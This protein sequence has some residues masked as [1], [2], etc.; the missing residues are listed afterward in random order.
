MT[1][2]NFPK[3][4]PAD[5]FRYFKVFS[6]YIGT[7][8]LAF[9]FVLSFM[10]ALSEGIGLVMLLPLVA[11]LEEVSSSAS[12]ENK[13]GIPTEIFHWF[14]FEQ[15]T[16]F[17][18]AVVASFFVLKGL[19]LFSAEVYKVNLKAD[20]NRRLKTRLY[21]AYS[22]MKFEYYSSKD[23]GHF[24]NVITA[25]TSKFIG[26][27]QVLMSFGA[28]ALSGLVYVSIAIALSWQ[29]GLMALVCGVFFFWL[30]KR[31]SSRVRVI[32]VSQAHESGYLNKLL[33]QS[34][35]G[36]KYLV[37]TN[38]YPAV[39][40]K[41]IASI[42]KLSE[43]ELRIGKLLAF[44]IKV[45][46]P[47][48]VLS[49]LSILI[50]QVEFLNQPLAPIVVSV[51]LFY[52]SLNVLMGL[53]SQWSSF[54]SASG[55]IDIVES[56]FGDLENNVER[57]QQSEMRLL[58]GDVAFREVSF[59]YNA[60]DQDVIR[61]LNFEIKAKSIIAFVGKSGAGK[62]TIADLITLLLTPTSGAIYIDGVDSLKINKDE[63]R[64]SIGYVSQDPPLFDDTIFN[65]ITMGCVS[66]ID[67]DRAELL[68]RVKK[69]VRQ[70]CVYE[71]IESLPEA[72]E[73]LVGERGMRL[74]GGQRQR[75]VLA[76]ELF[77]RPR[78][79]IL[80]EAT[81]ALDSESEFLIQKT[82]S[83]LKGKVTVVM[84]AHRLA[85]IKNA[86][87]IFVM[88]DGVL[89]EQGN[90]SDLKGSA[91]SVFSKLVALQKL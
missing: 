66:S 30:F 64:R 4:R 70:A 6:R 47:L 13:L 82:I 57:S 75:I 37:S 71:F 77:R 80:D 62:T 67:N 10:A 65:N 24:L 33:I 14:G 35:H 54:L 59:R 63:W 87:R 15:S 52:R 86:D 50:V 17:T 58:D 2:T 60:T 34:L 3:K 40:D 5:L 8:K 74:S 49:V 9:V 68:D 73:T 88:S 31:L 76:R 28:L 83:N 72:Y 89:V 48:A 27:S 36:H 25:Q 79:L 19:F 12:S 78:L 42:V 39:A 32:S 18:L 22:R 38:Q 41:V 84:I 29:F 91:D 51:L 16:S 69:V 23:S 85:T 56:Q 43:Y 11:G 53:Q 81:S 7:K 45:R 21:D 26:S 20:L 1:E 90:F 44:L 61:N 55:S 46:E